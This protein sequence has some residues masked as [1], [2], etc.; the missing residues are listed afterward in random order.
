MQ[1][2]WLGGRIRVHSRRASGEPGLPADL[3]SSHEGAKQLPHHGGLRGHYLQ[4]RWVSK[5]GGCPAR[6]ES[7]IGWESET[8]FVATSSMP[9]HDV[10]CAG[11]SNEAAADSTTPVQK[12]SKAT[13]RMSS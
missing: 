2:S 10:Q 8:I 6:S 12:F 11:T 4:S 3:T 13:P 7:S 1:N 5:V 9:P